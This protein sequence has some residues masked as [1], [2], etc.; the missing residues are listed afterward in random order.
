MRFSKYHG[1]GNDFLLVEDLDD[2]VVLTLELTAAMCDRFRGPGADGVIRVIRGREA[3]FA[4]EL[5]NA[6][7]GRAETSG[8]GMR[9]LGR[10]L[11]DRG[12]TGDRVIDVETAAGLKRIEVIEQDGAPVG[13]RVDMGSPGLTRGEIPMAGPPDERFVDRPFPDAGEEYR[14][15][16]VSMGNPHLVLFGD[17]DLGALDLPRIG[18]PLEHHRDFPERTNVEWVRVEDGRLD[19]RVWERG[20]GETLACGTGACAVLVAASL[21]GLSGRKAVVRFEGG[22]LDVEW[23]QDDRVSLAGPVAHVFEGELSERWLEA[24]AEGARR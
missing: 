12:L 21:M 3:P 5:W 22:D 1:A 23:G 16:A 9:C 6:D 7:G 17:T 14:A 11:I 20:V 13:A 8:N 15:A 4:M 19:V 18:P 2:R 24:L 10:F